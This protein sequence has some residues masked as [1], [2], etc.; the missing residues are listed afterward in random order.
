M[1]FASPE[2][3]TQ[4]QEKLFEINLH[5]IADLV[6]SVSTLLQNKEKINQIKKYYQRHFRKEITK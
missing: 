3:Y 4:G 2:Q 5:I 1:V 6:G